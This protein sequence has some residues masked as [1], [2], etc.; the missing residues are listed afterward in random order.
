MRQA[1]ENHIFTSHYGEHTY[2]QRVYGEANLRHLHVEGALIVSQSAYKQ[3]ETRNHC[4][5]IA[6]LPSSP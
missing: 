1:E 5:L 2:I 6:A 3:R 4:F